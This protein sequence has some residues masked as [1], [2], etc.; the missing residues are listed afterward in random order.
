MEMDLD[1]EFDVDLRFGGEKKEKKI[2]MGIGA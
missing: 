2:L 1:L